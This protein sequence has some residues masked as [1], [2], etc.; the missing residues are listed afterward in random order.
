MELSGS[1]DSGSLGDF[2]DSSQS[3]L[4]TLREQRQFV[5]VSPSRR[6]TGDSLL[7]PQR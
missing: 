4:K 6:P 5:T 1:D 3:A 2:G 7:I